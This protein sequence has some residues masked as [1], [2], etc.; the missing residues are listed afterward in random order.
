MGR[1]V[2]LITSLTNITCSNTKGHNIAKQSSNIYLSKLIYIKLTDH[3][4]SRAEY[5]VVSRDTARRSFHCKSFYKMATLFFLFPVTCCFP[6]CEHK[7]AV[8]V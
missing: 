8:F 4:L 7:M 2:A 1:Q 5:Q 6:Q 3:A